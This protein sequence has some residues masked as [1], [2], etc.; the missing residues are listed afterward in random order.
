MQNR[1]L[2]DSFTLEMGKLLLEKCPRALKEYEDKLPIH[3]ACMRKSPEVVKLLI[4]CLPD[5]VWKYGLNGLPI[6]YA[7]QSRRVDTMRYLFQIC[8]ESF[9]YHNASGMLPIHWAVYCGASIEVL[10]FLIMHTPD[11]VSAA[12]PVEY[13]LPGMLP[14]H[15]ATMHCDR[16]EDLRAVQL[17]FGAYPQAIYAT[18]SGG[19]TP[20]DVA[21][22]GALAFL[23]NQRAYIEVAQNM[24][25]L[26]HPNQ[27]TGMLPLHQIVDSRFISLGSVKLFAEAYPNTLQIADHNGR[28][29]LHTA[30]ENGCFVAIGYLLDKYPA[31]VAT[32]TE[33][34]KLPLHLLCEHSGENESEDDLER[35][36]AIWLL[37]R[38]HP[39]ALQG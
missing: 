28:L 3:H 20:F 2:D 17:L 34:G 22:E 35:V 7:C 14:L 12:C 8:P 39:L 11:G 33:D 21:T 23:Q 5:S 38:A 29:P 1:V 10:E 19:E 36:R 6:H 13:R 37:I 4:D 32:K 26:Q 9:E 31:A 18:D 15:F 27:L 30:C 24:E 25:L 16:P